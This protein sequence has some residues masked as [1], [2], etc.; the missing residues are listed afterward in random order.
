MVL[1]VVNG[2]AFSPIYVGERSKRM[3]KILFS[4]IVILIL[5]GLSFLY[6]NSQQPVDYVTFAS[7]E[8]LNSELREALINRLKANKIP[9]QIDSEGNVNIP[10]NKVR[11]AVM[12]C[13]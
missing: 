5:I 7:S 8:N 13:S 11:N 12:C 6:Y 2:T 10:E 3:R 1:I 9:Y 4:L